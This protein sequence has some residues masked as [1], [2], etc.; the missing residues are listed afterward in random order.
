MQREYYPHKSYKLDV[1]NQFLEENKLPILTQGEINNLDN[2]VSIKLF[3]FIINKLPK[4][5]VPDP[6]IS[7]RNSTKWLKRNNINYP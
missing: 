7:L 4:K 6:K 2:P 1:T 5:K 3:K